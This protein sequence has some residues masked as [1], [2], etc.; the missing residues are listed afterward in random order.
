MRLLRLALAAALV[1]GVT[2]AARAG[3]LTDARV[4]FSADR[5]LVLDGHVYQGKIWT[6]PGM[7]RHEQV[8][9]GFEPIFILHAGSPLGEIVLPQLHT[10]VEFVFPRA[11]RVLDDKR[12]TRHPVSHAVI[13]GIPTT[14]YAVDETTPEGHA[15]GTLWLSR[16][17]I[18]MR[19]A[20]TFTAP[21]GH[22]SSVRWEL[23]HVRI[24]PQPAALFV[25]PHGY[26]RLPAEAVAPL[27]GLRLKSA[28]H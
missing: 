19:V 18:P 6:M 9:K 20:G 21:H 8:I 4:G 7:E 15:V 1:A 28:R 11:L 5:T 16:E 24:G 26:S 14:K 3:T 12:L 13:E 27:L 23:S 22:V 10:T 17:G 25:P 2:V